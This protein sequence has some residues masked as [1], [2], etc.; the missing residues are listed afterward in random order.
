ML[1]EH[2]ESAKATIG[3][4]RAARTALDSENRAVRQELNSIETLLQACNSEAPEKAAPPRLE[5]LTLLYVGGYP[6]QVARL[7][8][9]IQAAGAGFLH[10][11]GSVEHHLNL[12]AGLASQANLVVFP[13]DCISH[14]AAHLAK[15]L[16]RQTHKRFVPL[17]SAGATSLLAALRQP[18]VADLVDVAN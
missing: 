12:L 6:H 17:R 11:D 16:C 3:E 13:V 2:F 18:E 7:R 4:E 8:D 9:L 1:T 5:G 15:Q 14:H 10:H